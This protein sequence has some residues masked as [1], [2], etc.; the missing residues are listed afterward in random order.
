MVY[1]PGNVY[2]DRVGK[3]PPVP[4]VG[5]SEQ[6]WAED[7]FPAGASVGGPWDWQSAV[8]L[9]GTRSH[10]HVST[11]GQM[12][13]YFYDVATPLVLA[14]DAVLRTWIHVVP[15]SQFDTID[16]L[17]RVGG[18]W[19]GIHWGAGIVAYADGG[20]MPPAGSW[21]PLDVRVGDLNIQGFPINGFR[22]VTSGAG[23]LYVDRVGV[24]P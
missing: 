24:L 12:D 19:I 9:S 21:I 15:G 20:E 8:A 23:T 3:V 22:I 16:L 17:W 4:T 11:G 10:E 18:T 14:P 6:V 2:M 5:L 13:A 1:G 7:G